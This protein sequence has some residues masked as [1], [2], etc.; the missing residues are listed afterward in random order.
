MELLEL[1]VR[2]QKF[3]A[4]TKS[5]RVDWLSFTTRRPAAEVIALFP[6]AIPQERGL[7]GY[8]SR[9][10]TP[11]GAK[12]LFSPGRDDVHVILP[13]S[14]CDSFDFFTLLELPLA[15]D[16][17]TRFDIALDCLHSTFT[18]AELWGFLQCG[19]FSS[20]SASIGKHEGLLS[21]SGYTIS[22]GKRGSPR[23][24]RIYDKAAESG[25]AFPWVRVEIETRGDVANAAFY[26]LLEGMTLSSLGSSL[27]SKQL[28]IY[29]IPSF[30]VASAGSLAKDKRR[31]KTAVW[32]LSLLGS[33]A[34][35][36]LRIP[37]K[38]KTVNGMLRYAAQTM[39]TVK[40]LRFCFPDLDAILEDSEKSAVVKPQQQ[41]A[42]IQYLDDC[43]EETEYPPSD[44]SKFMPT[45]DKGGFVCP[46]GGAL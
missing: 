6:G 34:P 42:V 5:Y 40:A 10:E 43:H 27:I 25:K 8:D 7:N 14:A 18:C 23:F 32:W 1:H 28:R 36:G 45:I 35:V 39:S 44:F 24:L 12:V 17:I 33:D 2:S 29:D 15:S 11:L 4:E 13:G 9:F 3:T 19:C 26:K 20:P 38:Q 31:I 22:I 21:G 37:R 41:T 30:S 16:N 46:V